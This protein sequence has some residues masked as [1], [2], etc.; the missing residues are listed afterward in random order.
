MIGVLSAL[1]AAAPVSLAGQSS[2]LSLD[3]RIDPRVLLFATALCF[4]TGMLSG[5][6]P[7]MAARRVSTASTLRATRTVGPG[8][9]AGPSAALLVSQVA[10]SL[11]LLVSAGLFIASLAELEGARSWA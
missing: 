5:I 8:R 3:L 10:V 7:A 2:G 1:I 4:I 6:V 11:V 9:L